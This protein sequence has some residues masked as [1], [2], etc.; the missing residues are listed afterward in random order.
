MADHPEERVVQQDDFHGNVRLED[1]AQLLDGHLQAAVADEEHH[2]AVGSAEFGPNG[3]RKPESHCSQAARGDDAAAAAKSEITGRV[4]LLLAD[5]GDQHRV[6]AVGPA[7]GVDRFAHADTPFGGMHRFA[8]HRFVFYLVA[9]PESGDPFAV[10]ALVDAFGDERQGAF[11]IAH[12]RNV[13]M[14]DLVDLRGVDLQVNHLGIGAEMRGASRHAVVET[15]AYGDQQVALLVLDIGTVVAVHAQ[16]AYIL[17]V[18]GRQGREPQQGRGGRHAA[19][20][21]QCL[22]FGFGIAQDDALAHHYQRAAG[23]V[24]QPRS[25]GDAL[26]VGLGRRDVTAYRCDFFVAERSRSALRVF[27]DVD[28][29]GARTA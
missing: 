27:G 8:D 4:H 2:F 1:R 15:H 11:H 6:V 22:Q 20:V 25:L 5:I 14:D 10:V 24:D 16:H 28:Y 26:C 29:D 12:D 9:G 3:R 23:L 7:H 17:R 19:L 18:A 13:G 21:E